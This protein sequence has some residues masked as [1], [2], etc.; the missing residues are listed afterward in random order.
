MQRMFRTL[1]AAAAAAALAVVLWNGSPAAQAAAIGGPFE[2]TDHTGQTVTE[3]SFDDSYLL[4]YFGYA[5]CPDVCPTELIIIGQAV[6]ELG[7]LGDEVQPLFIT[8][9][10]AR[11]TVEALA[12]YVPSFHPR[13]VGLTGSDEQIRE[14]AQAYRVYYRLN[15][16]DEDGNY[17]V[18]HTS[19]IYF[20]DPDGEYVTHFVYGQGPEKMAEIIR[21]HLD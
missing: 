5:W 13:L 17:L 14:A 4:V 6:D 8:V 3:E 21:K 20:M 2:L 19:Y 16:Q 1:I 10:P 11:D 9:D 7:A 18:D 15:E 12:E